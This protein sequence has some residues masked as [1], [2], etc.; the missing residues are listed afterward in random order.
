MAALF[1]LL[2]AALQAQEPTRAKMEVWDRHHS[3]DQPLDAFSLS[4]SS[5]GLPAK[6]GEPD[7]D[8]TIS[9]GQI[10]AVARKKGSGLEVYSLR[11]G[12]PVYR[13]RLQ[14]GSGS[15]ERI[16]LTESG[17]GG[18]VVELAW[19]DA[20]ARFRIGKGEPFVESQ[21]LGG[22][23]PL[24]IDCPGRFVVLPDFFADDILVDARKLPLDAV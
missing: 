20:S 9:N 18:A 3:S 7:G 15:L 24:R 14:R 11:S 16:A 13:A 5:A 17:R 2:A 21:S 4:R 8:L 1:F 12:E 23:A 19:K 22:D 10:L 6:P